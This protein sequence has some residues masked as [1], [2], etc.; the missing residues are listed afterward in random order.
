MEE[1]VFKALIFK[2]K[3]IEI[4]SFI[5]ELIDS[6]KDLNLTKEDLKDA[7]IKLVLYKF[8]KV[9]TTLPKG[10][11]IYKESN[12][13]KAREAGSVHLWLEKQRRKVAC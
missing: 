1:I 9:K 10:N 6:N 3:N 11:Y 8:I 4:E 7:L 12:F 13:F 2:T 5:N